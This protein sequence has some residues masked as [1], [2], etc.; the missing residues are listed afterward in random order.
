MKFD[1]E[2]SIPSYAER[3]V[4]S[5]V[6]LACYFIITRVCQCRRPDI[7]LEEHLGYMLLSAG[8]HIE[9]VGPRVVGAK[10]QARA[11][12]AVAGLQLIER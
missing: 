1:C 2:L 4:A 12:Q 8:H 9:I 7:T 6:G 3:N 11:L 10:I 5:R